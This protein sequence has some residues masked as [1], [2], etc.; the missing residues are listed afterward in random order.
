MA[1]ME[2]SDA[3]LG[4]FHQKTKSWP[5]PE[6]F[7]ATPSTVRLN[8]CQ[9][10]PLQAKLRI[11]FALSHTNQQTTSVTELAFFFNTL[12]LVIRSRILL[13]TIQKVIGQRG[14]LPLSQVD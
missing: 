1:G 2:S 6:T 12:S 3:R 7:K 13:E 8:Q 11:V 10:H 14:L 4:S 5:H 9:W